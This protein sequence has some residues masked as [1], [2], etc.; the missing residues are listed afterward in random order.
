MGRQSG[1]KGRV[2]FD[3]AGGGSASP[4]PFIAKWSL[5]ASTA[6]LDATAMDDTTKVTVADIPD[7]SGEFSGFYDSATNQTYTA[8]IDGLARKFYLYPTLDVATTYFFGT[9]NADFSVDGGV[10]TT[11]SVQSSWAAAT[12]IAKVG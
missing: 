7:A 6:F 9:I 3:V 5:K 4:L 8:A 10:G 11:V 12:P 2:Y 1:R